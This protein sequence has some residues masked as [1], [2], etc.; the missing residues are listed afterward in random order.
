M[1]GLLTAT[2]FRPPTDP[3]P[4]AIYYPTRIPIVDLN[5]DPV[6]DALGDPTFQAQ[7]ATGQAEQATIDASFK[8]EKNYWELYMNIRRAVFN[9][10][11]DGIDD[12]FKVSNNHALTGGNAWMEPREMFDQITA[13]YG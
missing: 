6:F 10:L 13:T 9:S 4:L 5:G 2:L 7:P 11:D 1:Y 8:H 12:A 3:G